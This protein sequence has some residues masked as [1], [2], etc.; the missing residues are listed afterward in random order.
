MRIKGHV[1]GVGYRYFA[2]RSA[3]KMRLTGWV[4]NLAD[5]DVETEV[6]GEENNLKKFIIELKK[7]P[8]G[9]RVDSF[10]SQEIPEK[11]GE[12]TFEWKA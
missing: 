2:I 8:L 12:E 7:G 4:R 11:F 6:Q 9:A 1:Q 3:Q 5:G 10:K